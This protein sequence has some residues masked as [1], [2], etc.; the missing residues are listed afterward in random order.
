MAVG[1]PK[2]VDGID[3]AEWDD[4]TEREILAQG[5]CYGP[6]QPDGRRI[7]ALRNVVK[8]LIGEETNPTLG[9]W[10]YEPIH[11]ELCDFTEGHYLW[12]LENRNTMEDRH[13]VLCIIPR[14]YGKSVC[15]TT[16]LSILAQLRDPETALALG[17]ETQTKAEGFLGMGKAVLA[18]EDDFSLFGWLYGSWRPPRSD[19]NRP[20]SAGKA[21]TMARRGI[22]RKETSL[23]TVSVSTGA[24]GAHP[25]IWIQDDP[26]SAEKLKEDGKALENLQAHNTAMIPVVKP[27][28]LIIYVGT[29]YH[30]RDQFGDAI[31]LDGV[32]EIKG[33]QPGDQRIQ[34]DENGLWS[35]IFFA[36]RDDQGRSTYPT[37]WSDRALANYENKDPEAFYCQMMNRPDVGPYMPLTMDAIRRLEVDEMAGPEDVVLSIHC[38]TAYR[39]RKKL[40]RGD[41]S[42]IQIWGHYLDGSGRVQF[43][44]GDSSNGWQAPEFQRVQRDAIVHWREL[45]YRIKVLTDESDIGGKV[46][47]WE[48]ALTGYLNGCGVKPPPLLGIQRQGSGKKIVRITSA[49]T[50]WQTAGRVE[51]Y[52]LARGKPKLM[53]QMSRIGFSSHDDWADAAADVFHDD[54]YLATKRDTG[55]RPEPRPQH[56]ADLVLKGSLAGDQVPFRE[57]AQAARALA[58]QNDPEFRGRVPNQQIMEHKYRRVPRRPI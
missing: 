57:R 52:R 49:A 12:W 4:E 3:L 6:W 7:G 34:V 25:D 24:T 40:A 41:E 38:D 48:T 15:V 51:L 16:G 56:P 9:G 10:W 53:D 20:W 43:M 45:G 55:E 11:G 39:D 26:I 30:D 47:T 32:Y 5:C 54:V 37:V 44:W 14:T 8:Y 42:V 27:N 2:R 28:G 17:S 58:L 29:R 18:G 13:R 1:A 36:A 19:E 50:Y 35:M 21:T 23:D 31:S 46:G 22:S 33:M